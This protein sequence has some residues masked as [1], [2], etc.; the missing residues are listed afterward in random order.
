ME[1]IYKR[2]P[3]IRTL[4]KH[5]NINSNGHIFGGWILSQMDSAAGVEAI[6]YVGG[7]VATV[8]IEAMKFHA[9]VNVGDWLSVY[10]DITNVGR[11]SLT[12]HIEVT[13]VRRGE[14]EETKVTEGDFVFVALDENH[15]PT[16]I[17]S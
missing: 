4:P 8:A 1:K 11:T 2:Q 5:S 3:T 6:R 12:I 14:E 17:K 10:T 9:P 7:P 16:E 13:V 15:G